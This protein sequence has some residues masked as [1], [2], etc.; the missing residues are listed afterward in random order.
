M[1]AEAPDPWGFTSRWYERRKYALT[2]A[3]LPRERYRRGFEAGCSIGV[4]TALLAERCDELLACD[5]APAAVAA[6]KDR[7]APYDDVEVIELAVPAAWPDGRFDLVVVS[8][9]GY[10][11][12]PDDL[13]LLVTRCV[14][15]LEP[16]GSLVAAHWRHPV[17]D[18]P[19]RGDD[20]HATFGGRPELHRLARYTDA[21]LLLEVFETEPSKS[22]AE[23]SGLWP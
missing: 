8:E 6:A 12:S 13:E 14:G 19:L 17:A 21:D 4:L 23:R 1:Y 11:L 20:V 5:V 22:V 10:Y 16:G 7:V 9:V 2:L 15:C 3:A 18:Y